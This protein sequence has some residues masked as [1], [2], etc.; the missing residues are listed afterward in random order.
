MNESNGLLINHDPL[1]I[2]KV[3]LRHKGLFQRFF[4]NVK[5]PLADTTFTMRHIW[6]Q[7]LK[8]TWTLI[9]N[10]LCVFGFLKD[11]F[12]LWGPPLGGSKPTETMMLCFEL[13]DKLNSAAGIS[14]SPTA[15]YIPESMKDTFEQV[16]DETG[17]VLNPWTTDY[18]YSTKEL[19][20]LKGEKFESQ[21][22]KVNRFMSNY[23]YSVEQFDFGKHASE[24]LK[25][26]D[27][28]ES[29]KSETVSDE[30]GY[31]VS[32]EANAARRVIRYSRS[33]DVRGVVLKIEGTTAGVSIGEPLT[34]EMCSNII[35][36]TNPTAAGASEFIFREFA[37]QWETYPFLNA[38]DDFGVDYLKK[39][40]LS[41]NPVM[42]I[43]S[44]SLQKK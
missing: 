24:C 31:E 20:E 34:H 3:T 39:T 37:K 28:W 17:A 25:L 32:A 30:F 13:L 1:Q 26:I 33:L 6:A 11:K 36:K 4:K 5:Q 14:A 43:N 15:T 38:Q 27:L 41:Y 21:R 44:Y 23:D 42:L 16:A 22:H 10:N 35:E 12:V 18:V 8:H 2:S 9:N 19:I 40:K 7:P 29:C